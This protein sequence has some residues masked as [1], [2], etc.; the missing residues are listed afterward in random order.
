M[1]KAK[2]SW[3]ADIGV[4]NGGGDVRITRSV[5][6]RI[7]ANGLFLLVVAVSASGGNGSR[8]QG[9]VVSVTRPHDARWRRSHLRARPAGAVE[10]A[11]GRGEAG[12]GV[13][14]RP[15][16]HGGEARVVVAIFGGGG[17]F[18]LVAAEA[19]NFL[20]H[21]SEF[22]SLATRL[23]IELLHFQLEAAA[24]LSDSLIFHL[25]L[26]NLSAENK[27]S[28]QY[29]LYFFVFLG[30]WQAWRGVRSTE[31]RQVTVWRARG[32]G[33]ASIERHGVG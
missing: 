9:F 32:F 30:A 22:V 1:R 20:L 16:K 18:G 26:L 28:V 29:F 23:L 24:L 11:W 4:Q 17:W 15:R 8:G 33:V 10:E 3:P 13:P 25:L 27:K 19:N 12:G 14:I 6:G 7:L 5:A 31:P 2:N 21:L